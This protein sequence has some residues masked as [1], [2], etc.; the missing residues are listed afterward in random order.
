MADIIHLADF[1]LSGPDASPRRSTGI[2]PA[3]FPGQ[4]QS[5]RQWPKRQRMTGKT[6]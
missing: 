1:K 5:G 3:N 2:F 6:G 4:A